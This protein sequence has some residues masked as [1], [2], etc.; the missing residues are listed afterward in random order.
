VD[1]AASRLVSV[2]LTGLPELLWRPRH[3][4]L[5]GIHV[6][7]R[8]EASADLGGDAVDLVVGDPEHL[9]HR[10]CT[11]EIICDD[12]QNVISPY[13]LFHSATTDRGSMAVG[14]KR[15]LFISSDTTTVSSRALAAA[16]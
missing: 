11:A 15:W 9:A 5:V 8:P 10:A 1:T 4:D 12:D 16:I 7:L 13:P 6:E 3:Q 2:N 14:S